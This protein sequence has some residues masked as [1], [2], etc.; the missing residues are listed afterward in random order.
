[1]CTNIIFDSRGSS[2]LNKDGPSIFR[3]LL[4][5]QNSSVTES[6]AWGACAVHPKPKNSNFI[7]NKLTKS[8]E[9]VYN[10]RSHS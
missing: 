1:M 6:V 8:L 9:P 5:L 4:T 3:I 2:S 7:Y 10:K